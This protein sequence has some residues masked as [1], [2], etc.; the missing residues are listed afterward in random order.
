MGLKTSLLPV[1]RRG[2]AAG[3]KVYDKLPSLAL[4]FVHV[5]PILFTM[6]E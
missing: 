5:E 4:P 6:N 3:D 1:V 2:D